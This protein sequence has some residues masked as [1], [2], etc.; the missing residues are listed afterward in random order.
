MSANEEL[1]YIGECMLVYIFFCGYDC[2]EGNS[3]V[4]WP[5]PISSEAVV[6]IVT[7]LVH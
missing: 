2:T 4:Y 3:T 5:C 7:Q 6:S 1:L